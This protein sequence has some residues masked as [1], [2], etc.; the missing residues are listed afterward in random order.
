[1]PTKRPETSNPTF[2]E[3][4]P[5]VKSKNKISKIEYLIFCK[6]L[7]KFSRARTA[8]NW[9]APTQVGYTWRSTYIDWESKSI[10]EWSGRTTHLAEGKEKNLNKHFF[11]SN[12]IALLL[13]ALFCAG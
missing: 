13:F 10:K 9:Q 2:T 3:W 1:M 6:K 7:K 12:D 5:Y 4:G 11:F 8:R